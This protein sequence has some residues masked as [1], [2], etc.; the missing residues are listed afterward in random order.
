MP[1]RCGGEIG[2]G[3]CRARRLLGQIGGGGD[4]SLH[5]GGG[6]WP[7]ISLADSGRVEGLPDWFGLG[8]LFQ[9]HAMPGRDA[10]CA[11]QDAELALLI[12][13]KARDRGGAGLGLGLR[14]RA[15]G[16][17]GAESGEKKWWCHEAAT[18]E[19]KDCLGIDWFETT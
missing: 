19:G 6:R 7:A 5:A 2:L 11:I 10:G 8:P 12:G 4:I 14:D 18:P 15:F 1:D 3:E 16:D 17:G 13:G 9:Q